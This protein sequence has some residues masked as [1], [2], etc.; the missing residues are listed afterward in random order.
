MCNIFQVKKTKETEDAP[1]E[2]SFQDFEYPEYD[3]YRAEAFLHQQKRT[4]CYSK[5]K[6]AYRMGKKHVAT[7]YAQQ[8]DWKADYNVVAFK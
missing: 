6:E 7:F 2:A 4:E 1:S 5:A 8:V 3:D